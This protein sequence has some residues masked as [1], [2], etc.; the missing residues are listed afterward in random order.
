[1]FISL[2]KTSTVVSVTYLDGDFS[3]NLSGID[4][5][6]EKSAQEIVLSI[7]LSQNFAVR[8]KAQ[9]DYLDAVQLEK[10]LDLLAS[11]SIND[12]QVVGGV[13]KAIELYPAA[14][15]RLELV[16]RDAA[17]RSIK[18]ATPEFSGSSIQCLI[19]PK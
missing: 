10:K 12:Q 15:L 18:K 13:K 8:N 1:M 16:L 2:K 19:E 5:K 11:L 4:C 14:S 6:I 9:N 3:N 7:D 17:K